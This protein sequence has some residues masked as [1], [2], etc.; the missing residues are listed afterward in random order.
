[1]FNNKITNG[2]NIETCPLVR[3]K[4]ELTFLSLILFTNRAHQFMTT[5]AI[6]DEYLTIEIKGVLSSYRV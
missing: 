2:S 3:F 4:S 5:V 6:F 1:M